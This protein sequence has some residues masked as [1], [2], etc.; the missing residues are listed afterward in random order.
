MIYHEKSSVSPSRSW[1]HFQIAD[2]NP[3]IGVGIKATRSYRPKDYVCT[4]H[5]DLIS[6]E[7]A[8]EREAAYQ[9]VGPDTI[10]IASFRLKLR[11]FQE[12][13]AKKN[14]QIRCYMF[15]FRY[16]S[17]RDTFTHWFDLVFRL[18]TACVFYFTHNIWNICSIDA[19]KEKR[20]ARLINH[21]ASGNLEPLV[22]TVNER[23]YIILRAKKVNWTV[24]E[25]NTF[26]AAFFHSVI[27]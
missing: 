17:S 10:S 5:G 13:D 11:I 26:V 18:M 3:E 27:S 23:P 7:E 2:I 8:Q 24:N 16:G 21:A 6:F 1:F 15:Y 14:E 20:K 25:L 9:Q 12:D 22:V 4:Y 19:T